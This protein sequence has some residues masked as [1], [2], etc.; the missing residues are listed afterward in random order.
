MYSRRQYY[1]AISL[2]RDYLFDIIWSSHSTYVEQNQAALLAH[3]AQ[4]LNAER[5]LGGG[6]T[7]LANRTSYMD[8]M[9]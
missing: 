4:H 9:D 6:P 2:P 8:V 3:G 5:E 1:P 7:S